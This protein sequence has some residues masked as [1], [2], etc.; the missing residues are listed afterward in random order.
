MSPL[1]NSLP[2]GVALLLAACGGAGDTAPVT[3]DNLT[4]AAVTNF[5]CPEGKIA[6]RFGG[7]SELL[8]SQYQ[9]QAQ[10]S[11]DGGTAQAGAADGGE[12]P[13]LALPPRIEV[14]SAACGTAASNELARLRQA[15]N[16]SPDCAYAPACADTFKVTFACGLADASGATYTATASPFADAGPG[17]ALRCPANAAVAPRQVERTACVPKF[18]R[19]HTRRDRD[20][21]CVPDPTMVDLVPGD[22]L[23]ISAPTLTGKYA[24]FEPDDKSPLAESWRTG[25]EALLVENNLYR[26]KTSVQLP[27]ELAGK[28]LRLVVWFTDEWFHSDT[29]QH[30]RSFRCVATTEAVTPDASGVAQLD[31]TLEL[32]HDCT[33]PKRLRQSRVD[34]VWGSLGGKDPGESKLTTSHSR[35]HLSLDLE[36]RTL[37]VKDGHT[38]KT[39]CAPGPTEFF[40]DA[41]RGLYDYVG[42][43][44]QRSVDAAVFPRAAFANNQYRFVQSNR[45]EIGPVS[46][47]SRK[48]AVEVAAY[49]SVPATIPLDFTWY[50]ANDRSDHPMSYTGVYATDPQYGGVSSG[51]D[52]KKKGYSYA[53]PNLRAEVY[54]VPSRKLASDPDGLFP[55]GY[56]RI[57]SIPLKS[58]GL[59]GTTASLDARL[60]ATV[61]A[62]LFNPQSNLYLADEAGRSFELLACLAADLPTASFET[63][64]FKPDATLR[65]AL[66]NA[67]L[68]PKATDPIVTLSVGNPDDAANAYSPFEKVRPNRGCRFAR[69]PIVL[70]PDLEHRATEPNTEGDWSGLTKETTSGDATMSGTSD[71]DNEEACTGAACRS[72]QV[73]GAEGAGE[74]GRSWYHVTSGLD[75]GA[76]PAFPSLTRNATDGK[77]TADARA[78]VMGYQVLDPDTGEEEADMPTAVTAATPGITLTIEPPFETIADKLNTAAAAQN[79]RGGIKTRW[80]A[81]RYSGRAGLGFG[82]GVRVPLQIGPIPG[83]LIITA[84]AGAGLALTFNLKFQPENGDPYQCIGTTPCLKAVEGRSFEQ[85]VE[86]CGE[87][88]GRLA[89][90]SSR[91]ESDA[92]ASFLASNP[93]DYWLGGQAS[94]KFSPADCAAHW[95][96]ARCA[97]TT[98]TSYRWLRDDVKFGSRAG[99]GAQGVLDGARIF[100]TG[101]T[102][103]PSLAPAEAAFAIDGTGNA[104]LQDATTSS[105]ALCRLEAARSARYQSLATAVE[106]AAGAGF[107]LSFCVPKDEF[108]ICLEGEANVISLSIAPT[109]TT[110][111]IQLTDAAGKVAQ[112]VTSRFHVDWAVT[113]FEA[114]IRVSLHLFLATIDYTLVAY[115]GIKVAEGTLVDL[116]VGKYRG[117]K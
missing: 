42:Y 82:A 75:R 108:G 73:N 96:A 68:N 8:S 92:V 45:M 99:V 12:V 112:N 35:M 95:D 70:I 1:R 91:A 10:A 21:N 4:Q 105:T 117:W 49:S 104:Y 53:P 47:T 67:I 113:L 27:R 50:T 110:D 86:A 106:V 31:R 69:T 62:Q 65:W 57:A 114:A 22:N 77:A 72:T 56:P 103:L 24:P 6:Y 93:G 40:Y 38:N 29:Y 64:F 94:Y 7:K 74:F 39:A 28:T 46:I 32:S 2:L 54:L 116:L 15:C 109:M 87:L 44:D 59:Q 111:F 52:I 26:L 23:S 98:T 115:D 5:P 51:W 66:P 80:N 17:L 83:E 100:T 18:C 79:A 48:A 78:E 14:L 58:S 107:G 63:R 13:L 60:P 11:P 61:K 90:L 101:N 25:A 97:S 41:T 43:Y 33:D 37:L 19:G 3:E 16:G 88:G 76:P 34:V 85:A 102:R 20:M 55:N 9:E 84:T 71:N 36:G 30:Y 81:S 89:E